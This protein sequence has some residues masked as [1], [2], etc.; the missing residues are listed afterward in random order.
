L[1]YNILENEWEFFESEK[2][3]YSLYPQPHEIAT[4]YGKFLPGWY[5][6]LTERIAEGTAAAEPGDAPARRAGCV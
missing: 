5:K 2:Q 4:L 6:W 3:K 1:Q